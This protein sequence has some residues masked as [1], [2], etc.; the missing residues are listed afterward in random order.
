MAVAAFR[1]FF[2]GI[3]LGVVVAVSFTVGIISTVPLVP[4]PSGSLI[5]LSERSCL[6]TLVLTFTFS[7]LLK[8]IGGGVDSSIAALGSLGS[9]GGVLLL[10]LCGE[11]DNLAVFVA[12]AVLLRESLSELLLLLL[13]LEDSV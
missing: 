11:T 6:L 7:G 3:R 12:G 2:T 8:V 1:L 10:C 5:L 9:R 4:N 13:S